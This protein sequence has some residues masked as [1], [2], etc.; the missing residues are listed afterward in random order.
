M[1]LAAL[2]ACAAAQPTIR[3]TSYAKPA[4]QLDVRPLVFG[5]LFSPTF[6]QHVTS[7]TVKSESEDCGTYGSASQFAINVDAFALWRIPTMPRW[8]LAGR[9][10]YRNLDAHLISDETQRPFENQFENRVTLGTMVT[11]YD[12]RRRG[13]SLALGAEYEPIDAVRIGFAPTLT[14]ASAAV[15]TQTDSLISPREARFS[16]TQSW[17]RPFKGGT[18]V[19]FNNVVFGVEITAGTMFPMGDRIAAYPSI[20]AGASLT[21]HAS[22][23]SWRTFSASVSLGLGFD[24]GSR[25]TIPFIAAEVVPVARKP[26]L[27]A[28]IIA[29]GVDENGNEYLDPIIE[30]EETPWLEL[31]PILPYMFFDSAASTIASR[32]ELVDD[33]ESALQFSVDSLLNISPLDVHWQTLNVIGERLREHPSAKGTITGTGSTDES[34]RDHPSLRL[35]RAEIARRYLATIWGIDRS[36]LSIVNAGTPNV[37]SAEDSAEGRA[38]NRRIEFAF[39]DSRI[40][41]PVTIRRMASIASPPAVRF[42]KEIV[43]DS[44]IAEWSL[45]V[46]QGQKELLRFEGSG[47][48]ESLKQNKLWSLADLRINRDLTEIRYRLDVRDVT[49]QTTAADGRFRVIQRPRRTA[50]DS[51]RMVPT[52]V[53]H[54]L[55]GFNYNSAELLPAHRQRIDEIARTIL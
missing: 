29:R 40:L 45:A 42:T 12:V 13:L 53:E 16:E 44:A 6:A 15:A 26:Y 33:P 10:G 38:E 1:L 9:V 48:E 28:T 21:S 17:T 49:G 22:N 35:D 46:V 7:F 39:D 3:D 20:R 50:G 41:E 2:T 52:L 34:P 30:I 8:W 19:D 47:D 31:V 11:R 23:V 5:A 14:F 37:P 36:R 32:Y 24:A 55:V 27:R 25:D 43:S 54:F 4:P 51:L 18:V